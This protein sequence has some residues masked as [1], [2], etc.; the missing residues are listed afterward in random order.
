MAVA[1][2]RVWEQ[3]SASY[4]RA[5]ELK[6]VRRLIA[7][8]REHVDEQGKIDPRDMVRVLRRELTLERMRCYQRYRR[9]A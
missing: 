3:A 9:S 8:C 1:D 7:A 6:Y 5:T 2:R 4:R